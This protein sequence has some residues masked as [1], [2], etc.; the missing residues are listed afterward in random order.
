MHGYPW[1][2]YRNRDS[3]EN[4]RIRI[5][6]IFCPTARASGKPYTRRLLPDFLIPRCVIRLDH[7]AETA[8][9]DQCRVDLDTACKNLGC[10]DDRTV[11]RHLKRF[12][13]AVSAAAITLATDRAMQPELGELPVTTPET[14]TITRLVALY[15]SEC[16]AIGRAGSGAK[17]VSLG[18]ILQAALWK[19]SDKKPS[20]CA[21]P[22]PRPP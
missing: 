11:R 13:E 1:R 2:C 16:E 19:P 7:L 3:G 6:S 18:H 21:K 4:V 8:Q 10:V 12:D 9:N 20:G 5:V 14:P 17:P 15:Q 22:T